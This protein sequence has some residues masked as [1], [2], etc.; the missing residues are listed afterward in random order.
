MKRAGDMPIKT[1]LV[2]PSEPINNKDQFNRIPQNKLI[3]KKNANGQ[4]RHKEE[5]DENLTSIMAMFG[6]RL[7][8]R[9]WDPVM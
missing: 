8:E 6:W 4:I 5:G 3:K 7:R 9:S 2:I 1:P